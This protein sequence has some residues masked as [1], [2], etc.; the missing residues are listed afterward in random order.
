MNNSLSIR[1]AAVGSTSK[2]LDSKQFTPDLLEEEPRLT[3]RS[4]FKFFLLDP[5]QNLHIVKCGI[6]LLVFSK[7]STVSKFVYGTTV[8][9]AEAWVQDK[10]YDAMSRS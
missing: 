8:W 5:N 10:R 6:F 4:H 7:F 3:F 9:L 2:V 1:R